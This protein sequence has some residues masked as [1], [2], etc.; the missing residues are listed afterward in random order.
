MIKTRILG[1]NKIWN[2][3]SLS[4]ELGPELTFEILVLVTKSKK[5]WTRN[6]VPVKKNLNW[7]TGTGHVRSEIF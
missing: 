1:W 3:N 5:C 6:L 7:K 4:C 2:R